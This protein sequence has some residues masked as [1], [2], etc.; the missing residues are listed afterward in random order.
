M[1]AVII[2]T[3]HDFNWNFLKLRYCWNWQKHFFGKVLILRRHNNNDYEIFH[4]IAHYLA[5]IERKNYM[6]WLLSMLE[7]YFIST[8]F[9]HFSLS[10]VLEGVWRWRVFEWYEREKKC[11]IGLIATK[12][13]TIK[14]NN[15]K[16]AQKSLL[17]WCCFFKKIKAIITTI[18]SN[19][20]NWHNF[21]HTIPSDAIYNLNE[22]IIFFSNWSGE[23]FLPF[24]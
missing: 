13:Y 9:T 12:L 11:W 1:K 10:R 18:W 14:N 17:N 2:D 6:S 22:R 3:Q 5:L 21:P 24:N 4:R 20:H 7:Y 19:F 8:S 23:S 16:K 15:N